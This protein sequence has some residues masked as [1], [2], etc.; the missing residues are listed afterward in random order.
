[1]DALPQ[2]QGL[3]VLDGDICVACGACAAVCPTDAVYPP[4]RPEQILLRTLD[5]LPAVPLLLAC[6]RASVDRGTQA[7]VAGIVRHVRCLAGLDMADLLAATGHGQRTLWL[8]DTACGQCPI[9]ALGPAIQATA[10]AAD[11]I[12]HTFGLPGRLRTTALDTGQLLDSPERR[13]VLL[14]TQ[15]RLSR[16]ELFRGLIRGDEA[17]RDRDPAPDLPML[18]PGGPV[19]LRL[20]KQLP[21][22]RRRLLEA[23][24]RLARS[25]AV[26]MGAA[27]LAAQDLPMARVKVQGDRC[28][29]CGLCARFC[30]TEALAFAGPD[31]TVRL[32]PTETVPFQLAFRADLCIDCGICQVACPE[33]AVEYGEELS[34]RDLVEPGWSVLAAGALGACRRCGAATAPRP[35]DGAPLCY[36]CRGGEGEPLHGTG[37]TDMLDDL[38]SQL[39]EYLGGS[40]EDPGA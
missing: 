5:G 20:P 35:G 38:R 12:L 4:Q 26:D 6:P 23:L 30:P 9:G 1:M 19:A 8:D 32:R 10:R 14:G 16:R 29:G 22:S 21:E 37:G 28:S 2:S 40:Q 15:P 25:A 13:P 27:T 31:P 17:S 18:L 11:R 36:A 39:M 7:P 3:P 24:A 34:L 33:E